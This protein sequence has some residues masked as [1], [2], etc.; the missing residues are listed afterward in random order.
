MAWIG[1]AVSV[2]II[3]MKVVPGVPG[4]FTGAEWIAFAAW[5]VL[6][7]VFWLARTRDNEQS[8]IIPP[9]QL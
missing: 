4:S 9:C 7:V 2:A 5:S 1:C 8:G 6:G 3:L